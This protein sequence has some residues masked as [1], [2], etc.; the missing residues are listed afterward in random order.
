MN[1]KYDP[2]TNTIMISAA[3][4][5]KANRYG[6][7]EY[8]EVCRLRNKYPNAIVAKAEPRTGVKRFTYKE[9]G[10]YIEL[11]GGEN[12]DRL[13]KGFEAVKADARFHA[14]AYVYVKDWFDAMFPDREEKRDMDGKLIIDCKDN[15]T[16]LKTEVK[17]KSE[18][19]KAS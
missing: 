16:S 15:V 5:K 12:K 13:L 7:P 8:K 9:M 10:E 18:E 11:N 4:S 2:F 6:T 19:K 17:A 3:A 14:N 1:I